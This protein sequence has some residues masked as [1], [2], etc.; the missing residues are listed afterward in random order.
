MPKRTNRWLTKRT[1]AII[2]VG[3]GRG[4]IIEI[5]RRRYVV[6]AAHCLPH[7]PST[8]LARKP[9]E[10]H[11]PNVLGPVDG[12]R[13]IWAECLFVDPMADVVV[14]TAPDDQWCDEERVAY[15]AFMD[16]RPTLRI[17]ALFPSEDE[18]RPVLL[19]RSRL[20]VPRRGLGDARDGH[21]FSLG[22]EWVP[23]EIRPTLG[24]DGIRFMVLHA[25]AK[26]A[27]TGGTSGSPILTSEGVA[28]GVISL[29]DSANPALCAALPGW[30]V[31]WFAEGDAR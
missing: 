26:D 28:V 11:Y 24:R 20:R 23:C 18:M 31:R 30:I 4:F 21:L 2:R 27:Y 15:D 29:G 7:L 16:A 9:E 13:S 6:S 22:R 5:N 10:S 12:E 1:D 17:G 8:H 3:G 25:E 19:R 14:L